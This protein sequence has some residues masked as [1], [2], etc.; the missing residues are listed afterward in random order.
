MGSVVERETIAARYLYLDSLEF[1]CFLGSDGTL[2]RRSLRLGVLVFLVAA[3]ARAGGWQLVAWSW[4]V[5]DGD[6][7]LGG[8]GSLGVKVGLYASGLRVFLGNAS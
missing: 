1:F 4:G 2:E 5:V 8:C 6:E 3:Y 7:V